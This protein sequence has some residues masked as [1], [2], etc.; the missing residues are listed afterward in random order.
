MTAW[1]DGLNPTPCWGDFGDTEASRYAKTYWPM[2]I[3]RATQARLD[4]QKA[5]PEK[6][7]NPRKVERAGRV[8]G[9]VTANNPEKNNA[10]DSTVQGLA[11]FI[12]GI[13]GER[14]GFES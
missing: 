6:A 2:V 10:Q 14:N 7:E 4:E 8:E 1:G 9:G 12:L 3:Q 11:L 13:G 5:F